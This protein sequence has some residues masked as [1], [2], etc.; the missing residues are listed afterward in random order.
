MSAGATNVEKLKHGNVF[1]H[2]SHCRTRASGSGW[3]KKS[4]MTATLSAPA[5]THAVG[6]LGA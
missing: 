6:P 4:V 1:A 5:A 3:V 2:A